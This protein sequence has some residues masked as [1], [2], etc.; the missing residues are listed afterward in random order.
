MGRKE[1]GEQCPYFR[2]RWSKVLSYHPK[3]VLSL[4]TTNWSINI[5]PL[6]RVGNDYHYESTGKDVTIANSM[7]HVSDSKNTAH[8][9]LVLDESR[10]Y[11]RECSDDNLSVCQIMSSRK[12]QQGGIFH[13]M[14]ALKETIAEARQ[15]TKGENPSIRD[16][17]L[18][19]GM[20]L[21]LHLI[22]K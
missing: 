13:Q 7:W 15:E 5:F 20:L 4:S 22:L 21:Y 12:C 17:V 18:R 6:P 9:C 3:G 2:F 1:F 10:W 11:D 8:H 14:S 19:S 16:G